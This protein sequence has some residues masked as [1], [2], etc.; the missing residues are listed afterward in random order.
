MRR[1]RAAARKADAGILSDLED[2]DRRAGVRSSDSRHSTSA[3]AREAAP[4]HVASVD[5]DV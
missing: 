1:G 3:K 5:R 2:D 4:P